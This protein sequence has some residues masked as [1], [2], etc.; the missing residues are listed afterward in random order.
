[1]KEIVV[2][3]S[4]TVAEVAELMG[5]SSTEVIRAGFQRLGLLLTIYQRL[6]FDQI[7]NLA[8]AFGLTARRDER[9]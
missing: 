3:G 9:H 8:A 5:V 4:E 2:V 7:R 1:M 6:D